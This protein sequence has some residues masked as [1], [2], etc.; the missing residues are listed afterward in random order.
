MSRSD[1]EGGTKVRGEVPPGPKMGKPLSL[2]ETPNAPNQVKSAAGVSNDVAIAYR[3]V[4]G[5]KEGIEDTGRC[6]VFGLPRNATSG[7]ECLGAGV[8]RSR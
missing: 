4:H 8:G 5:Y 2:P 6:V 3:A 7:T 1:F